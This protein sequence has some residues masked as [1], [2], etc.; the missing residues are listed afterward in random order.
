MEKTHSATDE[1]VLSRHKGAGFTQQKDGRASEFL[2]LAR[3]FQH[4]SLAPPLDRA[5]YVLGGFLG[6]VGQHGSGQVRDG[7]RGSYENTYPGDIEFA[8]IPCSPYSR[9]IC[10]VS[11]STP[12][13]EVT[14]AA[15]GYGLAKRPLTE[16]MV[17]MFPPVPCRRN[18]FT[19]ACTVK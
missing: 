19:H 18:C 8:R 6:E 17:T 11:P 3:S 7:H 13:L 5:W 16:P 2:G 9:A 14:Y 12:C 1:N 4:G 10:L 15:N